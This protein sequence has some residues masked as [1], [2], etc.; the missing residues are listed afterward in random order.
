M[1]L[2]PILISASILEQYANEDSRIKVVFREQNG[3]ISAASNSALEL[4]SGEWIALLDHDDMLAENAL[5]WVVETINQCPDVRLIYSDE[6]K[7]DEVGV[8]SAPYF[9]PDWNLDLFYSHNLITH[10]GVYRADLIKEIKGFRLGF[11]GAQD[12]DLALRCVE[13]IKPGQIRHI[14]RVLYHWRMHTNSTAQTASAKP[15]AMLAGEKALN[16]HLKNQGINARAELIGHGFRLHHPIPK[17]PPLVSLIIPTRNGFKLVQQCV[18]SILEKT[19][20]SNYEIIIVDNGSDD[21]DTIQYLNS[22][23]ANPKITVICD[24]RPF[25]YSALNNNA[26]KSAKGELIGLINDDIEVISPD[27]LTELVSHALR[28]DVGAVGACLWYPDDTLQHG[29]VV[30]GIAGWAGH[31]HKGFP[32]GSH[33]YVGRMS[34][35]SEFSAVTG[36]CLLTRKKLYE[37]LGGL[38]EIDLQIACNDV[39][40]CLRLKEAGY[41]IIWTPYAELYHH[42]SATRGFEDSPEKKSRFANELQFMKDRWGELLNDDPAYNPNLTLETQDFNLAWPPRVE[43]LTLNPAEN[44][45]ETQLTRVEKALFLVDRNGIGLEIGPSF[46]P[47]APK[48]AGFNVEVLDHATKE[49]LVEKYKSHNGVNVENIEQVDFVWQGEPLDEIIGR[50]GFMII[51]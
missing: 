3:H 10:L 39:D 50:K 23:K 35:I 2:Q 19:T 1:M 42:E 22:I 45:Q 28:P 16:E 18:N 48:K 26:V 36:A 33:G 15:Y 21:P 8:R 7:I 13:R 6:D 29:G 27:W 49:E 31:A 47:I 32:K 38:N 17:K 40:Y 11:E 46:N 4:V 44:D 24:N 41:R 34:L 43:L 5:F 30:L 12:Y 20:Y 51:L 14:P 9:K 37:Q 25:N